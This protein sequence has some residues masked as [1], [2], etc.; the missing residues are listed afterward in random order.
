MQKKRNRI[1]VIH[2][3]LHAIKENKNSIRSTPL[4]RSSNISSLGF[5]KY[6]KELMEKDFVK[7]I[8]DRK[9][10]KYYSLS[11]KGFRFLERYATIRLFIEDFDL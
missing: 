8:T 2:S 9:G 6:L 5:S 4:L 7:E 1:E 10:N 11:D 3:I